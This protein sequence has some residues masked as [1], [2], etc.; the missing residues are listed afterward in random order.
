MFW[1]RK[2]KFIFGG[3]EFGGAGFGGLCES[4]VVFD[5]Q[6]I[7]VFINFFNFRTVKLF[8]LVIGNGLIF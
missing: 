3:A 5:R 6:S 7:E 4:F 1:L 2:K 8:K